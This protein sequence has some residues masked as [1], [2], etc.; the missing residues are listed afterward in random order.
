MK[1][2]IAAGLGFSLFL[3]V[4]LNIYLECFMAGTPLDFKIVG[5]TILF[6]LALVCKEIFHTA[7]KGR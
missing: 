7:W 3:A 4:A 2:C 6:F 1:R 5:A